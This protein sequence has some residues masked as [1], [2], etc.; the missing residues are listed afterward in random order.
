MTL[1]GWGRKVLLLAIIPVPL[2]TDSRNKH[3][4]RPSNEVLFYTI[5]SIDRIHRVLKPVRRRPPCRVGVT[6]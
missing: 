3:D 5:E 1:P 2:Y 6:G 4:A